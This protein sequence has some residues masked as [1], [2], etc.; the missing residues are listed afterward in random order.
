MSLPQH[1]DPRARRLRVLPPIGAPRSV[2]VAAWHALRSSVQQWALDSQRA[3]CRNA[4]VA[5][6]ALAA[7]RAEREEVEEFLAARLPRPRTG[8]HDAEVAHDGDH[9]AHG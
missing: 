1:P 7:R 4:M 5:G 8:E 6:T 2:P 9:S 3:A